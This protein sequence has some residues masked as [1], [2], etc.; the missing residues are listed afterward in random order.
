MSTDPTPLTDE[1]LSADLDSEATPEVRARIAA[2]PAAQARRAELAAAAARLATPVAPLADDEVDALIAGAL[3]QPL[4]PPA[5]SSRR[6]GGVPQWAVAA[7]LVLLVG[8][9]LALIW[10]GRT[11]D[12]EERS[13]GDA[14]T[15]EQAGE[16]A[17]DEA[18]PEDLVLPDHGSGAMDGTESSTASGAGAATTT[19]SPPAAA[20]LG[21]LTFVGSFG[22]GDELRAALATSFDPAPGA[23]GSEVEVPAD[24]AVERCQDQLEITLGL[25]G[26][27]TNR[28]YAVVGDE[29]VLV[30]EYDRASFADGSPTQ[31]IAAVG[32][33]ACQEVVFFER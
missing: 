19:T 27:P 4:A 10:S 7:V 1:D 18:L 31:L 3:E 12:A 15:S 22:T 28:G 32:V 23:D 33:D 5:P 14:A 29:V 26:A 11:D 24:A 16:A 6:R 13:A 30:Y 20:A 17:A 2:D 21:P 9:G 8:A 25:E